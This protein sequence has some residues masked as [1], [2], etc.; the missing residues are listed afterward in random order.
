[1]TVLHTLEARQ[2][3]TPDAPLFTFYSAA[4]QATGHRSH[5]D[6]WARAEQL[7]SALLAT[8]L[9]PGDA[10]LLVFPPG[11]PFIDAF[12]ACLRVGL[13]PVPVPPPRPGG[14]Q[15]F[16]QVVQS[17]D[18]R[19]VLSGD[20]LANSRGFRAAWDALQRHPAWPGI[21]W[22]NTEAL[23]GSAPLPPLPT[24][25]T[26][27]FLQ[28]TSG[29][30]SAPR[31][32]RITHANLVHQLASNTRELHFDAGCVSV[33]WVPHYHDF[34]LI[35]GILGSIDGHGHLVLMDPVAFLRRP[36]LWGELITRYIT[37][38]GVFPIVD[39]SV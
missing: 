12:I 28:Y 32:V 24:D 2:A 4:G 20:T 14:H 17:C 16:V 15:G 30:T 36:A 13:V 3:Q 11:L 10:V 27:A 6:A 31:G 29:S 26:L 8:G 38:L 23:T 33:T 7:G 22:H 35:S 37:E 18:A 21:P 34:A 39:G 19:A 1:M 9:Q 5:A 25:D